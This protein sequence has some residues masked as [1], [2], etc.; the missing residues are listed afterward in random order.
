[1]W[2]DLLK[3]RD[4]LKLEQMATYPEWLDE[5][6]TNLWWPQLRHLCDVNGLGLVGKAFCCFHLLPVLVCIRFSQTFSFCFPVELASPVCT[7]PLIGSLNSRVNLLSKKKDHILVCH[8]QWSFS[9]NSWQVSCGGRCRARKSAGMYICWQTADINVR[10]PVAC[11]HGLSLLP[12]FYQLR[13]QANIVV[14]KYYMWL[15][16]L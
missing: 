10:A 9:K 3:E 6:Q 7:V 12:H 14:P 11:A 4:K 15:I 1:M 2:A 16:S 5:E 8:A 13:L